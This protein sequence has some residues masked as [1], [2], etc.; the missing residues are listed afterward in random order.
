MAKDDEPEDWRARLG[1]WA[2]RARDN[3]KAWA[4]QAETVIEQVGRSPYV[5]RVTDAGRRAG[6]E[7]QAFTRRIAESEALRSA[8]ETLEQSPLWVETARAAEKVRASE[9]WQQLE[10]AAERAGSSTRDAARSAAERLTKVQQ[11]AETVLAALDRAAKNADDRTTVLAAAAEAF[12]R[13]GPQLDLLADAVAVG[14]LQEAGAGVASLQGNELV[15]VPADGPVRAQLRVSRVVGQSARLAVGG[16]VGA[17]AAA[18]YGPRALM[19]RPLDRRGAD[20]GLIALSLGFFQVRGQRRPDEPEGSAEPRAAGWLVELAAGVA[21][22]IPLIS[23]LSAFELEEVVLTAYSLTE[24]EAEPFEAALARAPDRG[25]R[26]RVAR[27]LGRD[28]RAKPG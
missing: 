14:T 17:Y 15:F 26:R 25:Q 3:A 2:E 9:A 24:A 6:E 13:V 11:D 20:L 18:F 19:I 5:E 23:D 22:G 8:R 28:A 1:G 10:S 16:Q 12:E 7:V 27:L 21:L 4:E